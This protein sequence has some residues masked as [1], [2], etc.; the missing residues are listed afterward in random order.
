MQSIELALTVDQAR[1][2]LDKKQD[3]LE[4]PFVKH[5]MFFPSLNDAFH[6]SFNGEIASSRCVFGSGIACSCSVWRGNDRGD[7]DRA[8]VLRRRCFSS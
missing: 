2:A 4:V 6:G 8:G 5:S 1:E 3:P 7:D